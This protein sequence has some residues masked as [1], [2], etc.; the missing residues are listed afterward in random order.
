MAVI[1]YRPTG[2]LGH[3]PVDLTFS[4]LGPAGG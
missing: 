1:D 3:G 4:Y 2:V